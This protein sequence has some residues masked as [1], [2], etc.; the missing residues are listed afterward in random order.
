MRKNSKHLAVATT[1]AGLLALAPAL[2][3]QNQGTTSG[4]NTTGSSGSGMSKS[5]SSASS[6][7]SSSKKTSGTDSTFV[8]NAAVGGMEE[9]Q[10]G[11]M[12]AQKA[13]NPEVKNFGQR[14]VDDHTKAN[15]QLQQIAAQKGMTVP[16]A[17]PAS[18]R[19]DIDRL[20]RLN[21]AAFDRTYMSMMVQDHKKDVSEFQKAAKSAKD[22]DI[23]SFASTTLPTLQDHLKMAQSISSSLSKSKSGS[24]SSKSGSTGH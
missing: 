20:T 7:K 15:S 23:K 18:K 21:G 11:Q 16:A 13:S 10:L 8:K 2:A 1:L 14:M 5:S 12:A 3:A 17:L 22:A 19:K 4:S 9:V 24:S 6:S